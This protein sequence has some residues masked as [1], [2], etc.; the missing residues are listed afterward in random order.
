MALFYSSVPVS[1]GSVTE[2]Q[3]EQHQDPETEAAKW[4]SFYYLQLRLM[5]SSLSSAATSSACL[6][7][8]LPLDRLKAVSEVANQEFYIYDP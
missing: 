8:V 6:S 7:P 3:S 5:S 2:S 4:N 1:H